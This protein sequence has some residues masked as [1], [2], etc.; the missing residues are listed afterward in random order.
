MPAQ[1][2][3][4]WRGGWICNH[5]IFFTIVPPMKLYVPFVAQFLDIFL[6]LFDIF[7]ACHRLL[8]ERG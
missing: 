4:E 6:N 3:K 2:V 5:L 7:L 1:S 8:N